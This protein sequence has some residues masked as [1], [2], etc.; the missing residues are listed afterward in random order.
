M[1]RGITKFYCSKCGHLFDAPDIEY[2]ATILSCPQKC[3]Q[4]GSFHTY[5]ERDH[6]SFWSVE[7]CKAYEDML[8][9]T[10]WKSMDEAL[11]KDP[12]FK[13]YVVMNATSI[14]E[15]LRSMM[16]YFDIDENGK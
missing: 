14:D 1:Y 10:M 6:R 9:N 15:V 2:M 7:R 5:T 16:E 13:G 11:E 12:N 4:C 3:P 8:Y